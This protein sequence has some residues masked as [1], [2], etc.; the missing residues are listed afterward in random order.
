MLHWAERTAEAG[1]SQSNT[2]KPK[3]AHEG[4]GVI[5]EK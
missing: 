5:R 1:R 4:K 3:A 2:G